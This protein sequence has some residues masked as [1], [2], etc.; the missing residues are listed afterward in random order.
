MKPM[1]PEHVFP[2]KRT[3]YFFLLTEEDSPSQ[4]VLILRFNQATSRQFRTFIQ[5]ILGGLKFRR[6]TEEKELKRLV[7]F[8]QKAPIWET[9]DRWNLCHLLAERGIELPLYETYQQAEVARARLQ[10]T[11]QLLLG[12]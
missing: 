6:T 9:I 11:C 10:S 5:P 3:R 4:T 7:S 12:A 1:K 2:W 8:L